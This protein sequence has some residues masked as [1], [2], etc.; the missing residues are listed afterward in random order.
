MAEGQEFC[1]RIKKINNLPAKCEGDWV[2]VET[3]TEAKKLGKSENA[4]V[5]LGEV[6]WPEKGHGSAVYSLLTDSGAYTDWLDW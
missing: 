5:K 6:V 1:I 2:F 4:Q 3:A